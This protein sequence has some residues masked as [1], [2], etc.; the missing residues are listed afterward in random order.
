MD[1]HSYASVALS[2]GS[3]RSGV[4]GVYAVCID[5]ADFRCL[6]VV[7]H[8]THLHISVLVD[9]IVPYQKHQ[10]VR[11]EARGWAMQPMASLDGFVGYLAGG[12]EAFLFLGENHNGTV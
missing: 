12:G 6:P 9:T 4:G 2:K 7:L 5:F 3:A 8:L 10:G 11:D 1:R